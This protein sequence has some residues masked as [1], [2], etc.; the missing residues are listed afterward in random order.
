MG[1]VSFSDTTDNGTI[2]AVMMDE[3]LNIKIFRNKAS[4]DID[5]LCKA[6]GVSTI[7]FEPF[8][9][10]KITSV[11]YQ[12]FLNFRVIILTNLMYLVS[13]LLRAKRTPSCQQCLG[14]GT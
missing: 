1:H 3:D 8:M 6:R 11:F 14:S 12:H 13:L 4:L 7:P 10:T 9:S 5:Q 2:D